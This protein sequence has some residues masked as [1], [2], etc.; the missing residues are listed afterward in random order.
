MSDKY[1]LMREWSTYGTDY[2]TNAVFISFTRANPSVLFDLPSRI[3]YLHI[4][5]AN[6]NSVYL[7][8]MGDT[9]LLRD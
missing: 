5:V 3:A 8:G 6:N 9:F 4:G 1:W 7:A 2:D